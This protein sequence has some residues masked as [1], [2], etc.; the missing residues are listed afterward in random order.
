ML[1]DWKG[2]LGEKEFGKGLCYQEKL[3]LKIS[4]RQ[5]DVFP[6]SKTTPQSFP[7]SF[8]RAEFMPNLK[9]I[10]NKKIIKYIDDDNGNDNDN[11]KVEGVSGVTV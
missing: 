6:Q 5:R 10:I 4:V 7:P 1:K 8:L 11:D 9:S 2:T 3:K